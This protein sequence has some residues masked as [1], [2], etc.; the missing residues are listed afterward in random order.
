M[1]VRC[2]FVCGEE[3]EGEQVWGLRGCFS[4]LRRLPSPSVQVNA[5]S[6]CFHVLFYF[7]VSFTEMPLIVIFSNIHLRS[8]CLTN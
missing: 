4:L 6:E 7:S 2:V 8:R 1:V 3:K 5:Q